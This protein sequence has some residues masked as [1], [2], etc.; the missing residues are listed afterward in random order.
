MELET[1]YNSMIAG[2]VLRSKTSWYEHDE[3]SSKL[4]Y[5]LNLK[6]R[7]EAKSHLRK[8][9]TDSNTEISGPSS[10][11]CRVKHFY[12]LLYKRRT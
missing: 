10:I 7:N 6:N 12:S 8:R 11:M 5:F 9:I 2:L 4:K 1:L 3:K